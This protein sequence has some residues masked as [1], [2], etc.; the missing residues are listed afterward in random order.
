MASSHTSRV[1]LL[2]LK[3]DG[4]YWSDLL[5]P[6]CL[7]LHTSICFPFVLGRSFALKDVSVSLALQRNICVLSN[8]VPQVWSMLGLEIFW[9]LDGTEERKQR[10]PVL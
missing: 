2:P 9:M 10:E 3:V 6:S 4:G 8:V 7:F 1:L 5:P